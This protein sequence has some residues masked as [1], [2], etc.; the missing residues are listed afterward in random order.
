[1]T[2]TSADADLLAE[3]NGDLPPLAPGEIAP[4]A[5][6]SRDSQLEV[7][8]APAPTPAQAANAAH[9]TK[10]GGRG[11]KVI[12][13]G[14]YYAANPDG[15]GKLKKPYTLEVGLPNLDSALSV[16]KN[17]LLKALLLKKYPDF[18]ADRTCA[19]VSATP[20]DAST[21]KSNNLAYMDR[22]QLEAHVRVAKVP[23]DPREYPKVTD[24]R[25]AIIDFTQT[26]DGFL[27]REAVRQA[28]R[29]ENA[30]L[31]ALNDLNA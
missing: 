27:A 12:V 8:P 9:A 15:R 4:A 22:E 18:V 14:E 17:K 23:I 1:M 24:L 2:Q 10:N 16:I 13:E 26:P 28:D 21:P 5:P 19:I 6:N 20:M 30:E 29:K 25:E 3:L 31:A 7:G 11:F